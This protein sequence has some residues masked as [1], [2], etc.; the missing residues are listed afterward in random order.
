VRCI[1]SGFD[2]LPVQD[3]VDSG[4]DQLELRGR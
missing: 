1:G 2:V 3:D 4:K